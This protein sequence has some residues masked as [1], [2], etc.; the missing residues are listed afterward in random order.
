MLL[1][2]EWLVSEYHSV[3]AA[4]MDIENADRVEADCFLVRSLTA[5]IVHVQ[6]QK[7]VLVSTSESVFHYLRFWSLR[8]V[9][10]VL[11]PVLSRLTYHLNARRKF[12]QLL[13]REWMLDHGSFKAAADLSEQETH[14]RALR[15]GMWIF[16]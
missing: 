16:E 6:S 3:L 5:M 14:Q 13:R 4:V 15:T 11:Q 12:G 9:A 1:F 10:T 7:G 8:P 2:A